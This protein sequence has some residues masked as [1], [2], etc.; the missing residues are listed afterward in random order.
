MNSLPVLLP[1]GNLHLYH[2]LHIL[3][4]RVGKF[5]VTQ[6]LWTHSGAHPTLLQY[7]STLPSVQIS[8]QCDLIAFFLMKCH[9][10]LSLF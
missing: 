6:P 10:L 7:S 4:T 3:L 8:L 9:L 1:V 5:T 2:H